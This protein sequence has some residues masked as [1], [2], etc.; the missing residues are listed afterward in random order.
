MFHKMN[1]TP[2]GQI[3]NH[4]ISIVETNSNLVNIIPE[5]LS[6]QT[7]DHIYS[8]I[9]TR[10][11]HISYLNDDIFC[12][13]KNNKITYYSVESLLE[14][15]L[16]AV[17]SFSKHPAKFNNWFCSMI[18]LNEFHSRTK[19]LDQ[20]LYLWIAAHN[21]WKQNSKTPFPKLVLVTASVTK[22]LLSL[23]PIPPLIISCNA[24]TPFGVETILDGETEQ[25]YTR[26]AEIAH[27]YHKTGYDG[28]YIIFVPSR[29]EIEIVTRKLQMLFGPGTNYL[30]IVEVHNG[31]SI[32]ELNKTR[33]PPFYS[34]RKIVLCTN[35]AEYFVTMDNVSLVV[36]TATYREA[37]LTTDETSSA[38]P[39]CITK[40]ISIQCQR[41]TGITREGKYILTTSKEKFDNF[42]P[43]LEPQ[44]QRLCIMTDILTLLKYN[45]DPSI[46]KQVSEL[47]ISMSMNKL[48]A[49]NLIMY[50]N[51][52]YLVTE[53]GH[54]CSKFP[55]DLRKSA[56]LYHLKKSSEPNVFLYLAVICTLNC[57]SGGMI[58]LPKKNPGETHLT[59][60][61][62]K[63]LVLRTFHKKFAGYSDVDTIFNIWIEICTHI[64]PFYIT[65]LKNFCHRFRLNF[66]KFKEIASVLK[67]CVFIG[68]D[69]KIGLNASYAGTK[70]DPRLMPDFSQK[71][72]QLLELTHCDFKTS[73]FHNFNGGL[74]GICQGAV[75]KV[76]GYTI[77]KMNMGSNLNQIYYS[78]VRTQRITKMG[79][80][81]KIINIMHT[82]PQEEVPEDEPSI[83]SDEEE[84]EEE[85]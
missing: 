72:Y 67:Q 53:M 49:L 70:F 17:S 54:F 7:N 15:M 78:I 39:S 43:D 26:A 62:R 61:M 45:L 28:T 79:F 74:T 42:A 63:K 21:I 75:H 73:V 76:D 22:D 35:V 55:L 23:L 8:C 56:M 59:Y 13:K 40:M 14:K 85:A 71:F 41:R 58:S 16:D 29:V 46:L 12:Q 3:P 32:S 47:S 5:Y 50:S 38:N 82:V 37:C 57:Y 68:N 52:K 81:I 60:S 2:L 27:Q 31:L 64:N 44:M 11:R 6:K 25:P 84:E 18:I 4:L 51:Q 66:P 48:R 10:M 24:K 77:C 80:P 33:R 20:C 36:D 83:F 34:R 9:P 19:E 65:D 30:D 69:P 1:L